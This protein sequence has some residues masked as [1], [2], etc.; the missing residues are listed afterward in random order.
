MTATRLRFLY[1]DLGNVLLNYDPQRAARQIAGVA[2]IP[3]E[4][5]WQIVYETDIVL[6]YERGEVTTDAFHDFFCQ[7]AGCRPDR[8][9]FLFAASD[10]FEINAAIVPVVAHLRNAGWRLGI[11]SN[12][13][14][15]HWGLIHSRFTFVRAYFQ[16]YALSHELGAMKPAA[17]IYEAAAKLA[18]LAAE[19]IFF[20]D[21][22]EENVAAAKEFGFDA[23]QY[24]S[25]PKLADDLRD[26]GIQFNY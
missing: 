1:F 12:T 25:V 15:S 17:K 8:G 22:R 10:V 3:P 16:W 5:V 18:D 21:D 6:R 24:T 7:Q 20:V 13:N 9:A 26:R 11:L 23:V 2:G 4:R 19:A 14:E